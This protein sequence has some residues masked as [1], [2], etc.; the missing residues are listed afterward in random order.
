M[1]TYQ[2]KDKVEGKETSVQVIIANIFSDRKR[3]KLGIGLSIKPEEFGSK[4]KLELKSNKIKD[5][6]L[7]RKDFLNKSKKT[8]AIA[9]R[10]RIAIIESCIIET[11]SYFDKKGIVPTS[12]EFRIIFDEFRTNK[13]ILSIKKHKKPIETE[14]VN[15]NLVKEFFDYYIKD[16]IKHLHNNHPIVKK[17]TI[18]KY[19]SVYHHWL[20]YE[21]YQKRQ[22][23]FSDLS[24][25]TVTDFVNFC[26]KIKLGKI[27]LKT[28][29]IKNR[30]ITRNTGGYAKQ[31]IDNI[32]DI[33]ISLVN[34]AAATGVKNN[35]NLKSPKL[36]IKKPGR[37]KE[38]FFIAEKT[39]SII[40]E[41]EP[42]SKLLQM[43]K[44]YVILG[45]FTGMRY[46]S[47]CELNKLKIEYLDVDGGKIPIIKN[48]AGKTDDES[49]STV[50]KPV[51]DIYYRNGNNFPKIYSL[52][53]L[54][55]GI[56]KLFKWLNI[57]DNL[58]VYNTTFGFDQSKSV[59]LA[60]NHI[61]SHDCRST[62]ISNMLLKG[63]PRDI[64]KSMT[65]EHDNGDAFSL[66]DKTS[67]LDKV[68]VFYYATKN[69]N[70][71]IY[72]Y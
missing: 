53:Y 4:G 44:D 5:N 31:T 43:A 58:T 17:S 1:I 55:Q 51:M 71:E 20:N 72:K 24:E 25:D 32:I 9:L 10:T 18:D 52:A 23:L 13:G 37:K 68:R 65:H 27:K 59:E 22:F 62:F 64:V 39:L 48:I 47:I 40:I 7:Y 57:K 16:C 38:Y 49:Y 42:K 69:L 36:K 45:C 50:F 56:R 67:S 14:L 11:Q 15:K 30:R 28:N 61:S 29:H 63:V 34:K 60:A 35:I 2:I 41:S 3:L 19:V 33:F 54:N 12:D 8:A 46:Q 21:E 70:S 66:Y 26:T 6:Y